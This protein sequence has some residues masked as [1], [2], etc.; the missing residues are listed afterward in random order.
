MTELSDLAA[1]L[2]RHADTVHSLMVLDA[3]TFTRLLNQAADRCEQAEADNERLKAKVELHNNEILWLRYRAHKQPLQPGGIV[4]SSDRP[5]EQLRL[6]TIGEWTS[7]V[8]TIPGGV[9][10]DAATKSLI[11]AGLVPR[12]FQ[13][14]GPK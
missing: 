8:E 1:A 12:Y 7:I 9:T 6:V 13:D 5:S 14:G 11:P 2:R 3:P 4:V 10:R